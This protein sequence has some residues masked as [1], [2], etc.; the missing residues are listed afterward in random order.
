MSINHEIDGFYK[1]LLDDMVTFVAVLDPSGNVIFVNNTPLIMAGLKLEDVK[2]KKFYDAPWWTYADATRDAIK[3]DIEQCALGNSMLH[4]IQA[5][6][7]D[8]TLVWLEYSMHPILDE[9]GDVRYLVPEGRDVT[10]HKQ[11]EELLRRSQKMDALGKLTGGIAHDYNNMLGIIKGYAGLLSDNLPEDSKLTKY[12]QYIQRAA[13]RG[14]ALTRKLLAF[15]RQKTTETKVVNIN[16]QLQELRHMLE[17]SLTVKVSLLYDL[18]DDLWATEMDPGDLEDVI[19]NMSINALHAMESGGQLSFRTT[20]QYISENDAQRLQMAAGDYV[21]LSVADTGCG[22]DN[23]TKER[24]F[25]PFFSTKDEQGT[26]LGLSQVYS[27]VERSGGKIEVFSELGQGTRFVLY[28]LKSQKEIT[29]TQTI[30]ND[31]KR[32]LRGSETLLVVDDEQ[33]MVDL[34]YEILIAQGYQVLTANDG[35]EALTLLE[36]ESADLMISDVIMPHMDGYQLASHVQKRYPHI[37]IQIV[38][39][40]ES[41]R[42]KVMENETLRQ[43][44]LYKPYSSY[45]L[46]VRVRN[47][48]DE[49][50]THAL[51]FTGQDE[52]SYQAA[53][54]DEHSSI[55]VG[56]TVI[57]KGSKQLSRL[58][59]IHV[60]AV[61]DD[62]LNRI[63]LEDI[64]ECEGANVV[65][66]ENGQQALARLDEAGASSFDIVLMDVE[67]PVMDGHEATRRIREMTPALPVIGLTAHALAEERERCLAA[68]MVE[69]V[70]KPFDVESL[71]TMILRQLS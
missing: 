30:A 52:G 71:V 68:G 67:M 29:Q 69:H 9:Q 32:N 13:E 47:L 42:H 17:K 25:D 37:K 60:L 56:D 21:L 39:G 49:G 26:G 14:T 46:L 8:G 35:E 59:G 64:L 12:T 43:Q 33:S 7:A 36:T 50:S 27:F 61:D 6:A 16:R 3:H 28:F 2:G 53:H 58:S 22:M 40:F 24:I 62:E 41:D 20:N 45:D 51:N 55:T 18:A 44:I 23:E 66:A 15:T 57:G 4:E 54:Q 48:L 63:L 38:S 19:I 11:K 65:V 70:I 31:C 34:A 1:A 5:K 10:E